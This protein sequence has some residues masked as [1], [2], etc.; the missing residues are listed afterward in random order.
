MIETWEGIKAGIA[1]VILVVLGMAVLLMDLGR[2]DATSRR[3][4]PGVTLV[5]LFVAALASVLQ[6]GGDMPRT[7]PPEAPGAVFFGG[8]M[9]LD[10]FGALLSALVCVVAAGA[11]TMGSSY[12][13]ERGLPR[14][15]F[16]GLVLFSSAGAMWMVQSLDLV[17]VFVSVEVLS[18]ALYILAGYARRDRRSE[19]AAVKYFLLGAFASGFLLY[20]IALLYGAVGIARQQA[21]MPSTGASFTNLAVLAETLRATAGGEHPLV[22]SPLFGVGIALVLVGLCFK[23]ALVPFHAYAPDVYEGSPAPVSAFM[24]GVAKIAAFGVLARLLQAVA[25]A[26]APAAAFTTVLTVV[27]VAT[28]VVGNA[29]AVRQRNVK[30][31]LAF[32][33]VAHAGYLLVGVLAGTNDRVAPFSVDATV[34]YLFGYVLMNLGAFGMVVWLGSNG[35]EADDIS[36][37]AGLGRRRPGAAAVMTVLLLSLAGVPPS[38]GFL[39]KL[40]VFLAAIQAGMLPLAVAGLLASAVGVWYYLNLIVTMYFREPSAEVPNAREGAARFVATAA[41]ILVVLFG[42]VPLGL[43]QPTPPTDGAAVTASR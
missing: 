36:S 41:A 29:L 1:P 12:I 22:A 10:G 2:R 16:F 20:G 19:E 32:S 33:S 9:L 38:V 21:G 14:G 37:F 24:S 6:S 34:F 43:V 42:I 11:L 18:V 5:G 17:N 30:R 27:A 40:Y 8:G 39:G 31:L 15:E 4:I 26:G 23:A 13:E 7:G 3:L 28:M 35:G 25:V